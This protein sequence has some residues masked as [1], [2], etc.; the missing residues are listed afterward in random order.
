MMKYCYYVEEIAF[1]LYRI[2][3]VPFILLSLLIV[4]I[5]ADLPLYIVLKTKRFLQLVFCPRNEEVM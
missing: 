3:C 1:I 5:F 2:L 4:A